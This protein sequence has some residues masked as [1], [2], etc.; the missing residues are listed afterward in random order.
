[1]ETHD[2]LNVGYLENYLPYSDTDSRG[3]VTGMVKDLI[4]EILKALSIADIS[5]SYRG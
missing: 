2:A 5:V 4:P 1:M 3:E